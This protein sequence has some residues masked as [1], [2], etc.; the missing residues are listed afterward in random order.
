MTPLDA[1]GPQ[2]RA[3]LFLVPGMPR[4]GG[5]QS[6]DEFDMLAAVQPWAEKKQPPGRIIAH[7]HAFPG[8]TR[9]LCPYPKVARYGGRDVSDQQSLERR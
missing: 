8:V 9:P 1:T 3:R 6:T 2:D 4:C 5:G 7:G